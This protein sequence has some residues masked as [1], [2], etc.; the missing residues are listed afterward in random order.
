M[1]HWV[2]VTSGCLS[3]SPSSLQSSS[4]GGQL[5]AEQWRWPR[6]RGEKR[7]WLLELFSGCCPVL[8]FSVQ[9]T[10]ERPF[11]W[12]LT[13]ANS[14]PPASP[15]NPDGAL[16][17]RDTGVPAE[18]RWAP[19]LFP[20]SHVLAGDSGPRTPGECERAEALLLCVCSLLKIRNFNL[21]ESCENVQLSPHRLPQFPSCFSLAPSAL[22]SSHTSL[23]LSLS[24]C[25]FFLDPLRVHWTPKYF[26]GCFLKM[27]FSYITPSC[28]QNEE[29]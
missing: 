2:A 4:L 3:C 19:S 25:L 7:Q 21:E 23:F 5:G 14:D 24:F 6:P 27:T 22:S 13:D 8:G 1:S 16:S 10:L 18:T 12:D 29:I 20:G 9:A 17:A 26:S 15:A 28:H 11:A